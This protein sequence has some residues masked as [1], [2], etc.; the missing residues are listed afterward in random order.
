[1]GWGQNEERRQRQMNAAACGG[2]DRKGSEKVRKMWCPEEDSN[3]HASRRCYLKAVRLPIPPSG[4]AR[5]MHAE[6]LQLVGTAGNVNEAVGGRVI[7]GAA[8]P[9]KPEAVAGP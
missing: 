6:A 5:H 2:N 9:R 7:F 1:M 3:L 8:I 4:P